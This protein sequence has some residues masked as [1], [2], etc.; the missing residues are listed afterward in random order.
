MSTYTYTQEEFVADNAEVLLAL[1]H[2]YLGEL[3]EQILDGKMNPMTV[4]E[5]ETKIYNLKDTP[6]MNSLIA[7]GIIWEV[8]LAPAEEFAVGID[9]GEYQQPTTAQVISMSIEEVAMRIA[10]PSL[11]VPQREGLATRLYELAVQVGDL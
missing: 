7:E 1:H 8:G 5:F 10:E 4:G 2:E 9:L 11:T 6:A 3:R